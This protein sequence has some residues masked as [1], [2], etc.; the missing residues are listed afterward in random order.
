MAELDEG[1]LPQREQAGICARGR[2]LEKW[3][4]RPG[5]NIFK[6]G[7]KTGGVSIIRKGVNAGM[8]LGGLGTGGLCTEET[9]MWLDTRPPTK[10][11]RGSRR[12]RSAGRPKE[13]R[14]LS[15][16]LR[17]R[18]HPDKCEIT[19]TPPRHRRNTA[20]TPGQ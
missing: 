8:G 15:L 1:G 19:R 18:D 13:T 20:G 7:K 2:L 16:S 5:D 10:R 14:S 11:A 3:Q 17:V 12:W 4:E 6:Q 9:R